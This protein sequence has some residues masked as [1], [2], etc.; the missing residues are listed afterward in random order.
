MTLR[1]SLFST[2]ATL[3][4][5][6]DDSCPTSTLSLLVDTGTLNAFDFHVDSSSVVFEAL[7]HGPIYKALRKAPLKPF[8]N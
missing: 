5:T 8:L 3:C 6:K 4:P 1:S 2:Y 7:E